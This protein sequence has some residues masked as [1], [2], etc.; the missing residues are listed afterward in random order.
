MLQKYKSGL[1]LGIKS[2]GIDKCSTILLYR[3]DKTTQQQRP[4]E[5]CLVSFSLVEIND[6]TITTV[7]S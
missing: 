2:Q 3:G 1:E 4:L 7:H 6:T 5:N